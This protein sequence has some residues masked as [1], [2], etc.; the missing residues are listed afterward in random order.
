MLHH[1]GDSEHPQNT[2]INKVIGAHEKCVL[3]FTEKTI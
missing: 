1:A 3:Y 2:E